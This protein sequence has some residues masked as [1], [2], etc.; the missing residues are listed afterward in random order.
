MSSST[1][2]QLGPY[3]L[4]RRLGRHSR[5]QVFEAIDTRSGAT[6]AIKLVRIT[7]K[8]DRDFAVKRLQL[9]ARM[10]VR[11][12]H[13]H[14]VRVLDADIV[15]DSLYFVMEKID[16]EPLSAILS[17][18]GKLAWDLAI[19]YARQIAEALDYLHQEDL[20]HLKVTPD[21]ILVTPDGRIRLTDM[22]VNRARK[23][24]WDDA[25]S[26]VLDTA[27]YLAPEFLAG[28]D[29]TEK[30]DLYSLGV[31]LFEM[32]TGKL[33]FEPDTMGRLIQRKK[34]LNPPAVSSLIAETPV[35]VD[36][37]VAQLIA[38]QP[39]RRLPTMHAAV[40]S[41][42]EAQKMDASKMTVAQRLTKGFSPLSVGRDPEEARRAL[43]IAE[44]A[45]RKSVDPQIPLLIGGLLLVVALIIGG[46]VWSMLPP[47]PDTLIARA[48]ELVE[49]DDAV[50]LAVAKT[51]C[52]VPLLERYPDGP[53]AAEARELLD[54]A[55][56]KLA[57]RRMRLDYKLDRAPRSEAQ[58]LCLNAWL[59]EEDDDWPAAWERYR[60]AIRT[61]DPDGPDRGFWLYAKEQSAI[62]AEKIASRPESAE[63]IRSEYA[64][65][66]ALVEQ[67][68]TD[69]ARRRLEELVA[70]YG[71]HAP[72]DELM[73]TVRAG[74]EALPVET[75]ADETTESTE[76]TESA[77]STENTESTENEPPK[78]P[79]EE[80]NEA[81]ET[82]DGGLPSP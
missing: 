74:L 26:R 40:L 59:R 45:K 33:P 38:G 39:G 8:V 81:A 14:L 3:R 82:T 43:G 36:A 37:L 30:C 47:N 27:A 58:Q 32:I 13:P 66:V 10:L 71:A 63:T 70:L 17:R 62:A 57:G 4:G 9:E 48:R 28:E 19:D 67:G 60:E 80:N 73:E 22:R 49:A 65:A 56:T 53:H 64:A 21:K 23:R 76:S 5:H 15:D 54:Q 78:A 7:S 52:L 1:P 25:R 20:L 41:L 68:E 11:L 31:I 24:R 46:V 6:V 75:A 29:V 50:T 16:A 34:H 72:L 79:T 18:R 77:E 35:W 61:I 51:D 42:V 55:E 2:Q 12:N 44:K 69:E